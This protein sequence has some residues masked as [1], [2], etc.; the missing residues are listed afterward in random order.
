MVDLVVGNLAHEHGYDDAT[1][2]HGVI[3]LQGLIFLLADGWNLIVAN[4]GRSFGMDV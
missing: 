1:S 2:C 4:L 3:A